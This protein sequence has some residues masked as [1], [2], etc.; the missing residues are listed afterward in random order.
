MDN[1]KCFT[2]FKKCNEIGKKMQQKY[3][4]KSEKY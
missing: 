2:A 4:I 1:K 3:Q